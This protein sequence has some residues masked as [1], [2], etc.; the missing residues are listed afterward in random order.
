MNC[1]FVNCEFVNCEFVD[2]EFVNCGFVNCQYIA[3]NRLPAYIF[4]VY[5][6]FAPD[7]WPQRTVNSANLGV[8]KCFCM[9]QSRHS[10]HGWKDQN[11]RSQNWVI[12]ATFVGTILAYL[13][14][15]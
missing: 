11:H 13:K 14:V 8:A 4:A 2:C 1:E 3:K 6:N 7:W 12:T 5:C 15:S 9:Q 10:R